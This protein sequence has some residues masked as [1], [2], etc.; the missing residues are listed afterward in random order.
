MLGTGVGFTVTVKVLTGPVQPLT[1]AVTLTVATAGAAVPLANP[2]CETEISRLAEAVSPGLAEQVL[3]A[4]RQTG[5]WLEK[6]VNARLAL[7]VML[8][9]WPRID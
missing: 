8:L 5:E 2:D 1:I 4:L 9:D 3:A 6:N 7:E